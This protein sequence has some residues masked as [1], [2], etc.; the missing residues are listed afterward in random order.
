M[1]ALILAIVFPDARSRHSSTPDEERRSPPRYTA[2][3]GQ[4]IKNSNLYDIDW[5]E[6]YRKSAQQQISITTVERPSKPLN[7]K[8]PKH[9]T[10]TPRTPHSS[11]SR[12]AGRACL[13][14]FILTKSSVERLFTQ[15]YSGKNSR[16]RTWD[17]SSQ[18]QGQFISLC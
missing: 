13:C 9:R 1:E 8:L 12:S 16:K 2:E 18:L 14:M 17:H 4:G 3:V 6:P 7:G 10:F 15:D 5:S 11:I